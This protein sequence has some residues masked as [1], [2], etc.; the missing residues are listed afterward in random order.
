MRARSEDVDRQILVVDAE[1]VGRTDAPSGQLPPL[2]IDRI[3]EA[4]QA[5]Q[6]R[7]LKV[8][9]VS[10]H[11]LSR[12]M[13]DPSVDASS[14]LYVKALNDSVIDTVRIAADY[15]CYFLT[16]ANV[17]SLERDWRLPQKQR[18]WLQQNP[19]MHVTFTFE[20]ASPHFR[21]MFAS[22]APMHSSP[23]QIAEES[24]PPEF[25]GPEHGKLEALPSGW[26]TDSLTPA[27][28]VLFDPNVASQPVLALLAQDEKDGIFQH[29]VSLSQNSINC[30]VEEDDLRDWKRVKGPWSHEHVSSHVVRVT[31]SRNP[32]WAVGAAGR[33]QARRRAAHLSL[34]VAYYASK[35]ATASWNIFPKD[36]QQLNC[37]VARACK[38]MADVRSSRLISNASDHNSSS[39]QQALDEFGSSFVELS[40]EQFLRDEPS[41][42][43]TRWLENPAA[44]LDR[45]KA[46]EQMNGDL[47]GRIV[48]VVQAYYS[49]SGSGYLNLVP[50][51]RVQLLF[52][53]IEPPDPEDPIDDHKGYVYGRMIGAKASGWLPIDVIC[54]DD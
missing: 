19:D 44:E 43:A 15:R 24:D 33:K 30:T 34:V 3:I 52:P 40:A 38:L 20:S 51:N 12:L 29:A 36:N 53:S 22:S 25:L 31:G 13:L 21:A 35:S 50:G 14:C 32:L 4:I 26:I 5:L 1:S 46:F 54:F 49:E 23:E 7:G 47:E 8:I 45:A 9:L 16:S 42:T 17:T 10:Q 37:L 2:D 6:A 39:A 18:T 41:T 28:A 27:M 11:D 48:V